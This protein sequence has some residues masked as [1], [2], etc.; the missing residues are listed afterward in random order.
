MSQ[1]TPRV[2]PLALSR[3]E[4]VLEHIAGLLERARDARV[5]IFRV[6]HEGGDRATSLHKGSTGWRIT[7]LSARGQARW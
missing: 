7:L 2:L 3:G 4:E 1:A 5:P 6:P